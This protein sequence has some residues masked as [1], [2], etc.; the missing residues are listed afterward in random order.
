MYETYKDRVEF[1]L[2]YIREA[3]AIDSP[4]PMEFGMIEDPISKLE[5]IRL[6]KQCTTAMKLSIPAVVDDMDDAVNLA[7][8]GWPE[9]L[10]LVNKEGSLTYVGGN[11]PFLFFPDE[12]DNAIERELAV[13]SGG[14]H[15]GSVK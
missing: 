14:G 15:K 3:H 2:V 8:H 1:V 9:R 5:R 7:Y 13:T 10:Y 6:A 12:L 4:L 11:G